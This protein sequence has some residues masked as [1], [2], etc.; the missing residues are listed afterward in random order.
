MRR[1]IKDASGSVL[2]VT[3][4]ALAAMLASAAIAVDLGYAYVIETRLQGTADFA[5]M[6]SATELPDEDAVRSRAKAYA[7]L[8]MP[9]ATH[10]TVLAD[11][12]VTIGN[13]DDDARVFTANTAPINAVRVIARRSDDNGNPLGTFFGRVLGVTDMNISQM[14]I[15]TNEGGAVP[16]VLTLADN[17]SDSLYLDSNAGLD[18]TNCSIHVNSSDSSALTALSNSTVVADETCVV[19]GYSGGGSHYSPIPT[20]DC[21][22][23]SDPFAGVPPPSYGGCDYNDTFVGDSDVETLTPGVYCGGIKIDSN[24]TVTFA[25]HV[26]YG[27]VGVPDAWAVSHAL[28]RV[29][30]LYGVDL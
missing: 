3:G 21:D 19:G 25:P 4:L 6:A 15:A 5:A 18:L 14:A 27:L 7:A 17:G 9:A 8:N 28:S 2:T 30:E 24:A 22:P 16:C 10:G 1:F 12:D 20:T 29:H 23:M 13:W 11:S 26:Y